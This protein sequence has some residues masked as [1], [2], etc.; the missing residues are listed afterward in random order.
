MQKLT[1]FL[2]KTFVKD[3]ENTKDNNVRQRYGYLGSLVGIA[4][5]VMLFIT[6]LI[7]GLM[8]NSIAV[9]ADAFN[10]LSDVASSM[11]TLIGF[12]ITNKPADKEHPFGH[13][14]IEY[15]SALIVS[16]MILLVGI[17]FIKTSFNRIRN[18]EPMSFDWISIG[19]LALSITVKLW[20]SQFNKKMG[21]A[22]DSKAMKASSFDSLSDVITTSV[23]VVSIILSKW[24]P[25]PIDGY[26]GVVVAL[27]IL[28]AGFNIAK[29]TLDPILGEAPDPELVAGI[30]HKVLSYE[31]ITGAHDLIIHNYGPGRCIASIHAEVPDHISIIVSHDIIDRAEKEISQ[32]L[33]V[34]ML[35]HMD[36][37]NTNCEMTHKIQQ[38]IIEVINDFD[39]KIS[40]HDFRVV[41]GETHKSL[42][43]DI[44]IPIGYSEA[45]EM[46]AVQGIK[47][48]IHK[49]Y[50][51]YDAIIT[52]DKQYA[53]LR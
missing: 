13:G 39:E 51:E 48:E 52:V 32:E 12:N 41:N 19:I 25:I 3:Y 23:V 16:F 6:K 21:N 2:I 36:P 45:K 24:I 34:Y 8:L 15:I 27:F 1:N 7:I 11:V 14:R 10:N 43:F 18:P 9:I 47:E 22:I 17:E 33:G 53:I 31:G 49:R 46:E 37:V 42:V 26:I 30:Q 28:Y 40:T 44:V 4:S 38:Q 50:P 29:D 35:I 5:N 20:Q